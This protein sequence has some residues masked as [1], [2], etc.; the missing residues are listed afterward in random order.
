MLGKIGGCKGALWLPWLTM[1]VTVVDNDSRCRFLSRSCGPGTST[2][3]SFVLMLHLIHP[4]MFEVY[5]VDFCM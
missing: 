4:E 3:L 2:C 5:E 1:M